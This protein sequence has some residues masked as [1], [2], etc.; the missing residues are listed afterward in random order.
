MPLGGGYSLQD[1]G[2]VDE[3]TE[4]DDDDDIDSLN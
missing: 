4:N 1:K 3:Q 2:L